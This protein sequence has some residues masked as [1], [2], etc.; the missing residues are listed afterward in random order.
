MLQRLYGGAKLPQIKDGTSPESHKTGGISWLD[1]EMI[2]DIES[3]RI[4]RASRDT[5]D[6]R[7]PRSAAVKFKP[8][9]VVI[10][11]LLV[12][13]VTLGV[14]LPI[15]LS[16]DSDIDPYDPSG[17]GGTVRPEDTQST[18][19]ENHGEEGFF[20][21]VPADYGAYRKQYVGSLGADGMTDA[22]SKMYAVELTNAFFEACYENMS[23]TDY[24]FIE[25]GGAY[26]SGADY[27]YIMPPTGTLEL[28][29]TGEFPDNPAVEGEQP[30]GI[31]IRCLVNTITDN[32]PGVNQVRL[33]VGGKTE[34]WLLFE[35]FDM[36]T[37]DELQGADETDILIETVPSS[38]DGWQC[39]RTD[40]TYDN[41]VKVELIKSA[42]ELQ[43]YYES[44]RESYD[45]E[46]RDIVYSDTTVG[47][48]DAIKPYGDEYFSEHDLV[49]V[50][51][52]ASSGSIRFEL[53]DTNFEDDG[54][55]IKMLAR[56]SRFVPEMGTHDMAAWH[57]LIEI[58][59]T[60]MITDKSQIEVR[61][62]S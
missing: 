57:M 53:Y 11:C 1:P 37:E 15:L 6:T 21:Y 52:T 43:K 8:L 3:G 2:R 24:K 34:E 12:L 32:F 62:I 60:K 54:N 20:I 7:E 27:E 56:I 50:V 42:E 61:F 9:A 28:Y 47:F 10:P 40:G 39:I 46:S 49:L 30:G 55:N 22:L 41:E 31:I 4:K 33:Y 26:E 14:V 36:K 16:G 18:V 23:A 17:P 35:R 25:N 38:G 19:E 51:L 44:N 29:L 59:K 58:P 5:R 45:L 48:A 13:V